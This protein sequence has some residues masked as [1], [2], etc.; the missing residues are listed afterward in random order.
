[1]KFFRDLT[2]AEKDRCVVVTYYI[3]THSDLGDLKDAAWNLAIGQSVGNPKVRNRWESDDL[4]ELSSC[5]IYHTEEELKG[6]HSGIV[7]IGFP[8]VNTDWQGDG[9]S[10]LMCQLMGGQLDIDVFK[11]CRLKKIDFPKDVEQQFLGPRQ[12]IT[13]IRKFVNRYDKPLSG[14]IVKPKTGM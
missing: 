12:G 7:K 11:V 10:H 9:I 4:F 8:K 2:D 1:M 5:V 14:A 13:G 6:R 3:E